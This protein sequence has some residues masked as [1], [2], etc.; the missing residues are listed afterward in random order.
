[1]AN[2]VTIDTVNY[3]L[4]DSSRSMGVFF[5]KHP[6]VIHPR[7][8]PVADNNGV[9]YMLFGL[10]L[11]IAVIRFYQPAFAKVVFSWFSGTGSRKNDP[12]GKQGLFLPSFLMLNFIVSTTLFL[13][14]LQMKTG[15]VPS[16]ILSSPHFWFF[17]AGGVVSFFLY[18]QVSA[19]LTGFVFDT[20]QQASLQMKNNLLWAYISGLFLTFL[21]LIYFYSG[22]VV[23]MDGIIGLW[24]IL[25]LF[26]WFKTAETSLSTRNFN[27]LHLFLYLCTVEIAP[28]FLLIKIY[29]M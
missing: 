14:V 19:F 23:I 11:L 10:L 15:A 18:V 29:L 20:G 5:Q 21:L 28:L 8:L 26:K 12:G 7:L 13:M 1:M 27:V 9:F 24:L 17:A 25:L 16:G 2:K 4:G 6:V 3:M 22:A